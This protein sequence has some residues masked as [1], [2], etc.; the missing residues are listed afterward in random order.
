LKNFGGKSMG[1]PLKTVF[2]DRHLAHGARMV[3]FGG[4]LMPV[5]YE[6]G[7]VHEHL[8]TRKRAGLFDVSHM[9]RFRIRGAGALSFLQR[10]LSNNAAALEVGESQYTLLPN[11]AGGAFDDAYLYRFI[12]GEYLL[13][14]N[15]ANLKSDWAYLTSMRDSG[16]FEDVEM[17]DATDDLAMLSLQGPLSEE[18]LSAHLESGSLPGPKRN[19]TGIV[20]IGGGETYLSRTGY[21]GEPIGFELF[22]K[23]E[24]GPKIW[25]LFVGGGAVPVGLGA[26]D[27]LRLEAG[28]PLYGHELGRDPGGGEIPIFALGLSRFAVSFSPLKGEFVGKEALVRQHDARRRIL[29]GDFSRLEDLPRMIRPVVLTGKGV[30]RPGNELFAGERKVGGVTSGTA[31]PYWKIREEG[32]SG[33]KGMRSLALAFID[34]TLRTGEILDIDIRGRKSSG[35]IVPHHL[36]S[37]SPPY[38]RPVPY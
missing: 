31:V 1:D 36:R 4:S 17:T 38:A 11:A 18:I 8:E 2:Y 13:V 33:E 24:K 29:K 26:R 9:G 21:T 35:V 25:D 19:R 23:R 34:S 30:A 16:P 32:F 20:R 15:A 6:G 28:L 14:V 5:Q 22:M 37:D 10:V 12:T 3:E 7:I 27:T